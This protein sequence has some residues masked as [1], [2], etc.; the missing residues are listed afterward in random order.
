MAASEE[1]LGLIHDGLAQ[2][3]L[4]RI[5]EARENPDK[6]LTPQ[7]MSVF[8]KF[9]KDNGIE[10][11]AVENDKLRNIAKELPDF[12]AEESLHARH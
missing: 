12:T 1:L 3:M 5:R 9:L 4:D 7:E 8:V 2:G 10:A 6:P 11:V